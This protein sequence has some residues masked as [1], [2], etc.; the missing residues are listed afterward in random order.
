MD[1]KQSYALLEKVLVLKKSS[2][3]MAVTTSEL[4][5]VA[6]V[7]EEL[8]FAPG[9]CIFCEEEIGSSLYLVKEG[10]VSIAKRVGGNRS[11][12]LARL[13]VGECFGEMSAIDEEVRSATAY[14]E[15][16]SVVLRISKDD[17]LDVL[18]DCSPIGIELLKIFIKRLR[19]ANSRIEEIAPVG[20]G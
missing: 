7:A 3:F 9:T 14:V 15:V 18:H 10:C 8:F 1:T 20:E 6:A 12:E 19:R 16:A 11:V 13:G 17:L 5:A 2:L 4:R